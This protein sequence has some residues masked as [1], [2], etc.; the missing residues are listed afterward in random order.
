MIRMLSGAAASALLACASS[1]STAPH[2]ISAAEHEAAARRADASAAEHEASYDPRAWRERRCPPRYGGLTPICWS[3]AGNPT[4]SHRD[5]ADRRHQ[6][7]ER[8]RAASRALRDAEATACADTAPA[9]REWSPFEHA[10]EIL[11]IE[12]LRDGSRLVGATALF[13]PVPGLTPETLSR[14]ASCHAARNAVL[15]HARPEMARCP[16]AVPGVRT[17]AI[18][19]PRGV[20][21]EIRADDPAAADEILARAR[22]AV[23]SRRDSHDGDARP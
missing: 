18:A 4:A 6:E 8:H 7:A 23:R 3:D 17:R 5:E 2:A 14:V 21:L 19:T 10:D 9:D 22:A 13:R 16:L 15:G 12:P 11:E 1:P 20:A